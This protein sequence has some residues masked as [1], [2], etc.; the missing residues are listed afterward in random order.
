V[1]KESWFEEQSAYYKIRH[2]IGALTK[3]SSG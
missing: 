1:S 2:T 3:I